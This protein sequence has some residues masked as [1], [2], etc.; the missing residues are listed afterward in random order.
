MVSTSTS[1]NSNIMSEMN[2][3][4]ISIPKKY[5]NVV[6]DLPNPL[7]PI[8][9]PQTGEP[10]TPAD[11]E[12]LFPKQLVSLEFSDQR[13]IP[14]PEE[15]RELYL[16]I[17]RVTPLK[18]LRKLEEFLKT[19]AR[20]YIKRED[21]SPTGSHK[22]NTAIPQAYYA[23]K[24]GVRKLTT[25]TGAGQWGSAL[26]ASARFVSEL[27]ETELLTEV[28]MVRSSYD[29]KPFRKTLMRLFGAEV[30]ASPSNTTEIGKKFLS[31][32]TNNPGSLG[33]AISEAVERA[34]TDQEAKYS[35]GSVL[36]SV[37]IHQSII[38][39]EAIEQLKVREIVPT[40]IVGCVGGGSNFAGLAFPLRIQFPEAKLVAAESSA[41]PAL[42]KGELRYDFADSGKLGPKIYGH[43]LGHDYKI[44]P[45]HAG[46]LRYHS[47]APLVSNL[48]SAGEIEPR[49]YHQTEVFEAGRILTQTEGLVPAPETAHAIKAAIDIA[50]EAKSSHEE[51][52]ILVSYSGHG[53]FD[54]KGYQAYLDGTL[55][56][57]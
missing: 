56:N 55:N 21:V 49:A 57:Y 16:Q 15:I 18:R 9:S 11:L 42:S 19:P 17:G 54:L 7:T 30:H 36:N 32:D 51:K 6:P 33:I 8:I 40:H 35:L 46:G 37:L 39:I 31:E 34:V 24:E 50:L 29:Q 48:L 28:F 13:F 20:I 45:V 5:Y 26:S 52:T 38:G 12:F 41:C 47:T 25:E 3:F 14:I 22:T 1:Q 2:E 4:G 53:L 44:P 27:L 10:I 43:T 23:A